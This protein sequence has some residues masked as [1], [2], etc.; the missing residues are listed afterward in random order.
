MHIKKEE[1]KKKKQIK[2]RWSKKENDWQFDYPDNAG[3]TMTGVFFGM[4]K[5]TGHRTDW[6]EE[7]KAML[8]ERG[9]DYR[10]F[11]ITCDKLS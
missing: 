4:V 1:R 7:L 11:K 2:L 9:Y 3:S 10:T 6:Q 5:T 8:T